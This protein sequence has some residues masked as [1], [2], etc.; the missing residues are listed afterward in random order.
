MN[1]FPLLLLSASLT[2]PLAAGE[3]AAAPKAMGGSSAPKAL[4]GSDPQAAE[5]EKAVRDYVRD[6]AEEEGTFTVEDD[7]LGRS[8]DAKLMLVRGESIR[9]LGERK[10]VAC[11][12]FKGEDEKNSQ[13]LDLDFTLSN[14]GES[15]TVDEIVIHS[16]GGVERFTY[17]KKGERVPVKE[18]KGGKGK[19]K[20]TQALPP[21][22]AGSD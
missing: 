22:D 5:I 17:N 18:K 6:Q 14:D 9:R 12:T 19:P 4:P 13:P 11:A 7:V 21:T 16:V 2:V 15:W 20:V 8:W 3:K 1:R 10:V